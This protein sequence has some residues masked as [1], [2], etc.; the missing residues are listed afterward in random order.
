MTMVFNTLRNSSIANELE[1]N[2]I[3]QIQG[4]FDVQEFKA[5][6]LVSH[7]TEEH[8]DSLHVVAQGN[9]EV[10]NSDEDN[11]ITHHILK[12]GDLAGMITFVGGDASKV[13]AKLYAANDVKILSL[14][15]S[16]FVA[17]VVSQPMIAHHIMRGV[18]RSLHDIVRRSNTEAIEM[19]NY[20]NRANGRY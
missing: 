12:Q 2:D 14:T 13:S 20:I 15:Q 9:I 11:Q 4:L 3:R 7:A 19:N 5:G 16:K 18:A 6:E 8:P 1:D 10:K 17:L